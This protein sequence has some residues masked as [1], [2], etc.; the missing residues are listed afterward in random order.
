MVGV[1][2]DLQHAE[3]ER[4]ESGEGHKLNNIHLASEH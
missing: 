3:E 1:M 4:S 2:G